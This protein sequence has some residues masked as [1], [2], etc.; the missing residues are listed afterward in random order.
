MFPDGDKD[1]P[2]RLALRHTLIGL[3]KLSRRMD[4]QMKIWFESSPSD[5]D[6]LRAYN[7]VRAFQFPNPNERNRLAGLSFGDKTLVPLQA[8]DLAARECFKAARNRGV[9]PTRKP[10]FRL[11]EQSAMVELADECLQKILDS[12]DSPIS[13]QAIHNMGTTCFPRIMTASPTSF[14]IEPI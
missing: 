8:A 10:L 4:Q 1:D 2:F 12:G 11:W 14:H 6:V 5:A 13:V 9:R 3:V 7:E